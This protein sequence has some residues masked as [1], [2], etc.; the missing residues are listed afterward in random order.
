MTRW[1]WRTVAVWSLGKDSGGNLMKTG[2][3]LWFYIGW[4]PLWLTDR[5]YAL[6]D[7]LLYEENHF[8]P[9][10]SLKPSSSWAITATHSPPFSITLAQ[11]VCRNHQVFHT[12]RHSQV[13]VNNTQTAL[14]VM[15]APVL[16]WCT[17]TEMRERGEQEG[18][19]LSIKFWYPV[20]QLHFIII[21]RRD[22]NWGFVISQHNREVSKSKDGLAVLMTV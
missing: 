13:S 9:S 2:N 10:K 4:N 15:A 19:L 20:R 16:W 7:W 1:R 12:N 8:Y 17:W 22:G 3:N 11:V 18:G 14:G 5:G 6:F 21:N